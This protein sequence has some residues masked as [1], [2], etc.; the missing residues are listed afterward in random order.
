M[1][2]MQPSFDTHFE[3]INP[4]KVAM[5]SLYKTRPQARMVA[6]VP[7]T[8][9]EDNATSLQSIGLDTVVIKVSRF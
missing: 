8:F 5:Y 3:K 2:L 6:I 7:D 9:S 4:A 1:F